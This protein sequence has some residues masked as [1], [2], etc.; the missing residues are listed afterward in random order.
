M[1]KHP[2]EYWEHKLGYLVCR[3]K[4]NITALG[5]CGIEN[6]SGGNGLES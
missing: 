5:G 1:A 3:E 6:G 4:L 2:R